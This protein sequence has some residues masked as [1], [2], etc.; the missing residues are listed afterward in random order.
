MEQLVAL[1][2]E[3]RDQDSTVKSLATLKNELAEKKLTQEKAQ[4]DAETLTRVVE[5]L[6]KTT[7]QVV[8][9]VPSL[10]DQVKQLDN[11]IL[12]L[13]T[14]LQAREL[15]LKQTTVANDY[16]QCQ[17]TRLTKKLESMH[18]FLLSPESYT[19]IDMLLTLLQHR[20]CVALSNV[21]ISTSAPPMDK[22][23]VACPP[24]CNNND[25]RG[26]AIYIGAVADPDGGTTYAYS[27][28]PLGCRATAD[29]TVGLMQAVLAPERLLPLPSRTLRPVFVQD[30]VRIA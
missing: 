2:I 29:A 14:E 25:A 30:D 17:G 23:A 12:D 4:I 20:D 8:V 9:W 26:R 13:L 10:E 27:S 3:H 18:L 7:Y 24:A 21:D 1:D 16:L 6:K 15:Y 5:E 22:V 28:P 11:K 19:L